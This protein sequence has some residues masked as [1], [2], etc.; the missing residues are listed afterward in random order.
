MYRQHLHLTWHC[1]KF[2]RKYKEVL[3]TSECQGHSVA[4]DPMLRRTNF[5]FSLNDL[6]VAIERLNPCAG[7]DS[8]HTSHIKNSKRCYRNLL[9]KLYNKLISRTCIPQSMLKWHKCQTAKTAL[10]IKLI[11]KTTGP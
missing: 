6:D 7:F 9:C 5:S 3:D 11:Q 1:K 8:V 4:T 10:E 2:Y